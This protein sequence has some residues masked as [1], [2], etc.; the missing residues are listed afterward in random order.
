[1]ALALLG[2]NPLRMDLFFRS[3]EYGVK[4]VRIVSFG[5]NLILKGKVAKS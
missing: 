4:G 1:L 5:N 2:G 3:I